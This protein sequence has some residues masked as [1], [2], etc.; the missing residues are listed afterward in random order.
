MKKEG[1][2]GQMNN[3]WRQ[4]MVYIYP[5]PNNSNK[6]I[7]EGFPFNGGDPIICIEDKELYSKEIEAYPRIVI[8][9]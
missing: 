2:I 4:R 7:S 3:K 5:D 1:C 8:Y 6:V 9:D